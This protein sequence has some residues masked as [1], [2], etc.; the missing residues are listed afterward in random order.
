MS[1]KEILQKSYFLELMKTLIEHNYMNKGDAIMVDKGFLT[2]NELEEIGLRVNIPPFAQSDKQMSAAD[3]IK[4]KKIAAW[5]VHVERAI[6][7]IKKFKI[8]SARIPNIRLG[9][10]NQIWHVVNMLLNFRPNIL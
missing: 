9:N 2:E 10:I 7:K 4:T 3:V 5:K 8:V 6:A 1:D